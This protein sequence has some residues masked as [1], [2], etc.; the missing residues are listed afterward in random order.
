VGSPGVPGP[1]REGHPWTGCTLQKGPALAPG[2]PQ[3]QHGPPRAFPLRHVAIGN[4]D[5]G[6]PGLQRVR[7]ARVWGLSGCR[8]EGVGG[9]GFRVFQ[10]PPRALEHT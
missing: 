3:G 6:L 4:E 8:G 9:E 1:L 5:C 7:G 10:P 2:R